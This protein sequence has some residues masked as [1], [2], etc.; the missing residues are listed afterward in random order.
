LGNGVFEISNTH[1]YLVDGLWDSNDVYSGRIYY[2]GS[3]ETDLDYGLYNNGEEQAILLYR[4][5]SADAWEIYPEF[6][7]GVGS[8]ANGDGHF[9]IDT[10]LRGQYA[11]ANGDVFAG[12]EHQGN[13]ESV[14]LSC[15]PTPADQMMDVAGFA[16]GEG[17]ALFDV[18][19]MNGRLV[20]RSS[21]RLNGSFTKRIDTS[22]LGSGNYI[23]QVTRANGE[24]LGVKQFAVAR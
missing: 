8:L 11:F 7:L 23:V 16:Q 19:A 5:S 3:Q 6:T 13:Y 18:Y 2:N 9:V 12:L 1:Y 15:Y 24:V 4:S 10:L 17:V 22:S 21:A 20:Q 14:E